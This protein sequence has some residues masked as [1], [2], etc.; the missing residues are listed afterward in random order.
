MDEQATPEHGQYEP[1]NFPWEPAIFKAQD[2]PEGY[3]MDIRESKPFFRK[4]GRS[5]VVL[6]LI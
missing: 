5:F 6:S 2:L 3:A 1:F 4:K